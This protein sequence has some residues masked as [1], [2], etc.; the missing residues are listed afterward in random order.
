MFCLLPPHSPWGDADLPAPSALI[1]R[2]HCSAIN[3]HGSCACLKTA[4]LFAVV[5]WTS[6]CKPRWLTEPGNP[7][8]CLLGG[9]YKSR[10]PDLCTNSFQRGAGGLFILLQRAGV[11]KKRKCPPR[12]ER[13]GG[14]QPA[15]RCMLNYILEPQTAAYKVCSQN[16]T[17]K[18]LGDGHFCS[19]WAKPWGIAAASAHVTIKNCFFLCYIPLTLR[20]GCFGWKS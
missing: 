8:V 2:G 5:L 10:A 12:P 15:P 17:R 9:K 14:S 7:G 4:P 18:R 20:T 13:W 19:L 3:G 1:L 6:E 16:C 11:R